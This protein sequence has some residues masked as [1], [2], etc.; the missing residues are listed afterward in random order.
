VEV[1]VIE[2]VE[3]VVSTA[4]Q[5][6]AV[7]LV[8]LPR[9]FHSALIPLSQEAAAVVV[10]VAT[11]WTETLLQRAQQQRPRDG[12]ALDRPSQQPVCA[13]GE[14]RAPDDPLHRRQH[15]PAPVRG[16]TRTET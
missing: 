15:M 16:Q 6:S 12:R 14:P 11:R 5:A 2:L 4:T 8:T 9:Y 10:V 13:L 7:M 1:V 3:V